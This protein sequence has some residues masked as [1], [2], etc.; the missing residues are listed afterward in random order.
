M[1]T[2]LDRML[3]SELRKLLEQQ[4]APQPSELA[5]IKRIVES[6]VRRRKLS[7]GTGFVLATTTAMFIAI[8]IPGSLTHK[9]PARTGPRWAT[10]P[11]R[12]VAT[13]PWVI[14]SAHRAGIEG[15]GWVPRGASLDS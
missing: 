7:L 3:A 13:D 8:A 4:T 12:S 1:S 9:H 11:E 15:D 6:R 5:R 14:A 10:A 2:A